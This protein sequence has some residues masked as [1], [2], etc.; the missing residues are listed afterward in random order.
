MCM[1]LYSHFHS[2]CVVQIC[3]EEGYWFPALAN[4]LHLFIFS[5]ETG[6]WHVTQYMYI[7]ALTPKQWISLTLDRD[8]ILQFPANILKTMC[9]YYFSH[10][11]TA[12][13]AYHTAFFSPHC[14]FQPT[15]PSPFFIFHKHLLN[16][17][18]GY[19]KHLHSLSHHF[20][21]Y[22]V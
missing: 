2:A 13:P 5:R 4:T 1:P 18:F 8:C 10:T 17:F 21:V 19:R 22:C 14:L 7:I 6:S 20:L 11:R 12:I 16:L 15:H 9:H 3:K